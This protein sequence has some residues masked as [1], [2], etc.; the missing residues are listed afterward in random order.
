MEFPVMYMGHYAYTY[1]CRD[2]F[3]QYGPCEVDWSTH[4]SRG[5]MEK[6]AVVLKFEQPAIANKIKQK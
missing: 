4:S 6:Y 5:G 3:S 1:L 2:Y